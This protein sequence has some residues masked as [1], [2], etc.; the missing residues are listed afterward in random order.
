MREKSITNVVYDHL[1]D[2]H[3]IGEMVNTPEVSKNINIPV[4]NVCAAF[5]FLERKGMLSLAAKQKH[6]GRTSF[7]FEILDFP[8]LRFNGRHIGVTKTF[9]KGFAR[10]ALRDPGVVLPENVE[11]N[12]DKEEPSQAPVLAST[13]V[14]VDMGELLDLMQEFESLSQLFAETNAKLKAFYNKVKK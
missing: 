13:E 10:G 1:V 12:G 8:T 14:R 3:Q 6:N 5:N 4:S 9:Q 7:V 2:N 11:H